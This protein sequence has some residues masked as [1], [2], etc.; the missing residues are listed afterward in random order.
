MSH[1]FNCLAES[2]VTLQ[3]SE[4]LVVNEVYRASHLVLVIL[5]LTGVASNRF[6]DPHEADIR[7]SAQLIH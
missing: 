2:L 4:Y 5:I 6:T 7:S 1:Y 3:S